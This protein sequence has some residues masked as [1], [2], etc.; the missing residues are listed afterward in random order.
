MYLALLGFGLHNT[1]RYL[2]LKQRYKVF[3]LVFFY[4]FATSL[5]VV[6]ILQHCYSVLFY[7]DPINASLNSMANGFSICIGLSQLIVV[8]ELVITIQMYQK[9]LLAECDAEI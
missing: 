9:E 8:V 1:F 5:C 3:P 7:E 2:L 4:V 6:R